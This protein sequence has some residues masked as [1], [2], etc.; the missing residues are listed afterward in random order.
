MTVQTSSHRSAGAYCFH[1]YAEDASGA[2]SFV[3]GSGFDVTAPAAAVSLSQGDE[4]R[5][6]GVF[7]VVVDVDPSTVPSGVSSLSV[8][9]WSEAGGQGGDGVVSGARS[10]RR[11]LGGDGPRR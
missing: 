4:Q 2:R 1:V 7:D 3:A 8:A 9:V 6:S 10:G 11:L 5:A